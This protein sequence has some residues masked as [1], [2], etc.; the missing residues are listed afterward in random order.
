MTNIMALLSYKETLALV[1]KYKLP[2]AR[3]IYCK[4][5]KEALGRGVHELKFPLVL[6]AVAALATHKTDKGL[7]RT[8]IHDS[9][10]LRREMAK[11]NSILAAEKL[12]PD[13]FLLQEQVK[14]VEFIIGSKADSSFGQVLVFGLGGVFVELIK[15]RAVRVLPISRDE[16]RKMVH[17]TQASRFF[18]GYRGF[19]VSEEKLLSLLEKAAQMALKEKPEELDFNPV[20]ANEAGALVV[21]ARIVSRTQKQKS[22]GKSK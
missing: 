14:G 12:V 3:E 5:A 15:Q 10:D 11:L 9:I 19:K 16:L 18:D 4:S 6:K 20:I 2:Y 21:D 1:S 8:N 13:G 7:V 17:E 22:R